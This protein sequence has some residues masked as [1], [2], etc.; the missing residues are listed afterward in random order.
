MRIRVIIIL[1]LLLTIPLDIS[2]K[3]N[4]EL[5]EE[6]LAVRT[7]R[8]TRRGYGIYPEYS[9]GV[10]GGVNMSFMMF[11]PSVTQ[12][13][14]PLN[15]H[16]GL[17]YR[18]IAEKYFGFI[19]EANYAQRGFIDRTDGVLNHRRFDY[20][21]VPFLTHIT[22]GKRL[23]RFNINLG[24]YIAYLIGDHR[25]SEANTPQHTLPIG[26]R[27]DYGIA[28]GIEFEFNTKYGIYTLDGRY[29]FGF[30]KVFRSRVGDT[31]R[32]SSNQAISASVSYLFPIS[33]HKKT[34]L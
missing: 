6:E 26:N 32:N 21:E 30:G 23:F 34:T 24:P 3:K 33:K 16:F 28:G 31:F 19:V 11:N 2:A 5:S 1:A 27:F 12:P 14:L 13:T 17:K 8:D 25:A 29:N 22:F 4:K 18:H 9:L 7:E 15:Y 20:I 10:K